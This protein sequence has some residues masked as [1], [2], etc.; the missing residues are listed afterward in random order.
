MMEWSNKRFD[1]IDKT[2]VE[3]KE[4]MNKHSEE[5]KKDMKDHKDFMN[6]VIGGFG[7]RAG[8]NIE[9][10]VAGTLRFALGR[11]D[12]YSKNLKLRQKL[13]DTDGL[14]G[15]K[16]R[17]YEYDIYT[18][19]GELIVFE[20]KSFTDKEAVERFAD[21]ADLFIR[22]KK[23][24]GKVNKVIITLD[25]RSEVVNECKKRGIEMP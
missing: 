25:K 18:H 10:M 4:D 5:T 9:D 22:V 1:T 11:G 6:V 21:K 20:V 14:I 23:P 7:T 13:K 24:E 15:P 2:I 3:I 8:E 17:M 19:N 12:I 16:E